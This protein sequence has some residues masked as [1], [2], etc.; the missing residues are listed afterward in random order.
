MK[1]KLTSHREDSVTVDGLGVLSPATE[2]GPSVMMVDDDAA[3]MFYHL[4]GLPLAQAYLLEGV[5]LSI[6]L[7]EEES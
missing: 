4:R 3:R 1:H 7:E 5:E 2:E 6:V